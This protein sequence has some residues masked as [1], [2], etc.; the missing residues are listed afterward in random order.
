MKFNQYNTIFLLLAILL[1][2]VLFSQK[3][4]HGNLTIVS[5]NT[6][7]NEFT[8]LTSN[9]AIGNST[10][11]VAASSLN[12]NGR[13]T[14][15][16]QV[17]DLVMIIQMQGAIIKTFVA[18]PGQDST[19]GQVLNYNNSGNYEF[20]E[21]Y[22]IPNA[23]SVVLDCGLKNNYLVSGK[24]QI[25]R[26]PRYN[27]LTINAGGELT[28]DAWNGSIAGVLA[29]EVNGLTTINGSVTATGLGFRGG[30]A[31]NNS[32]YG[33][34]RFVDLGG[35]AN[36]G[37]LKG[38]S[39]A[40]S[41]TDYSLTYGGPYAM[42]APANGGG[43]GNCHNAGG[44]GGANA[45][46]INTWYGYG[47][48]NPV[49]NVAYNLEW[50]G[51]AAIVSS[52]GGRGG[53][54]FSS[55]NLN[56]LAIAPGFTVWGGDFRRK[57]GGFGGRPL[58]YSTGK[59]FLGGG[60]G[61]GH[62]NDLSAQNTG[63]VGGNGGGLIFLQVYNNISGTGT[64]VSNGTAGT[65]ATGPFPGAFS[66]NVNGIDGCG[67]GGGGGTIMLASTGNATGITVN[68]NGGNGGNQI[69]VKGGFAGANTEA[70]GP[71]GGGGGGYIAYS[72]TA[73]PTQNVLGAIS[74]TTNSQPM[75]TFLPNGATNGADGLKDQ[76]VKLEVL[77][78]TNATVCVNSSAN[79]TVTSTAPLPNF[80]WYNSLTGA[81]QIGAGSVF[82]SSV[83]TVPGTYT[84]YA[85]MCPGTYR[86]PAIITVVG[87][88]T[89][90]ATSA[91][92]CG[93]QTVTLTASG[94]TS[95]TWNTGPT[96]STIA[97]SPTTTTIYTVTGAVSGCTAQATS[98]VVSQGLPTLTVTPSSTLICANQTITLVASGGSGTYSW[99]TGAGN[100][101]SI[102]VT[103][104][105]V[106]TT[107]LTNACGTA[108]YTVN[109]LD[110]PSNI[111]SLSASANTICAGGTVTLTASGTGTFAWSTTTVNTS[112]V[113]V[114]S[115]GVYNVTLSNACGS[116]NATI[117]VTNGPQPTI[118]VVPSQTVFCTGQTAT[119]VAQGSATSYTWV[120]GPTSQTFT[121][122]FAGIY[123][124]NASS[125]CGNTSAQVTVTFQVSPDISVSTDKTALCAGQSAVLTATNLSGGGGFVW[126]S[127]INTSS[128][129]PV[130][131]GGVY[132]VSY[133]NGCG[134]AIVTVSIIQSTLVPNFAPSVTSGIVPL[135]VNFTNMSFNNMLNQWNYGNGLLSNSPAGSTTYTL[136]GVYTVTLVIENA[137]GC[138]AAT[139]RTVEVINEPFGLIP[140][141][142]SPNGDGKNETFEIKGIQQFTD[143]ELQIFNRWGNKVYSMKNYDNSFDGTANY[144]SVNGKLPTGT[145]FYILSLGGAENKT[146][147]GYFQ[148]AY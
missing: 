34:L 33:G 67:G 51:R 68:A 101:P 35:G 45:G 99:S 85:G 97:V 38:E 143:S 130:F 145:Y 119:L 28:T 88:P 27:A 8:T 110:G 106:Y 127:S 129:E 140:Q 91:S 57:N 7:V 104:F 40:G 56:P 60:G 112:S 5:T 98:T 132:T 47:V 3:G 142:I 49:Y 135:T 147:N 137:E 73:P 115:A 92:I 64:V 136:P 123:T 32:N 63:G 107:T 24:T 66:S 41:V 4:K 90:A 25:V 54:S 121:T 69:I 42:G 84:V 21:V 126:S 58:D 109:I 36:E 111:P 43:G 1:S 72:N 17:G 12:A 103:V 131:S 30:T 80:F 93:A 134:A 96:T 71:G 6:R 148:L 65:N 62:V 114:G 29:V 9:A 46:N 2:N 55:A 113:T 89:V 87:T 128:I 22:A 74:G 52:G 31:A 15:T 20:A 11:S 39:I 118:A 105:G 10:I 146:Y 86:E 53:Y 82:T 83:F 37:G 81:S 95:Y 77:T 75:A 59:I 26:V 19:Y 144:K 141:L 50:P 70:E 94:A 117:A 14:S 116:S 139:T 100:T 44:G 78:T 102:A 16:L 122:T 18:V 61:A 76:N 125:Q 48:V 138:L 13:F 124:V 108:V 133:V 23:T 120:G 79:V